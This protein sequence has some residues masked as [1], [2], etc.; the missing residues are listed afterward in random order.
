MKRVVKLISFI[1]LFIFS[2]ELIRR[3]SLFL[4]PNIKDFLLQSLTPVKAISIG[5]FTTS[6]VQSSG[7]I[8]T[9]TA[10]F[11]GNNLINL[12]TV[13]YILI[14]ASL[15]TTITALII[16][17]I[18]VTKQKKDFR[19]G[20]EIALS[21]S[22]YSA[23][24]VVIVFFLEYY[25]KLFSKLSFFLASILGE[26]ISLLKVPNFV[27]LITSPIIDFLFKRNNKLILLLFAFIILI[28]TLKY[29]GRSIIEV[30]GGE[31]K[32]KKFI[33]KYFDSKYKAYL[34]GVVLTAMVFS[35]S[36]TIG[37]LVPLAVSRL[38]SLKKAIPFILGADLGTF[39]DVFL[40]SIIIGKTTAFATS[41]AYAL[42]AII[43]ALIFLPNVDFLHKTTKYVSKKLIK[44]S[45]KK[46]LYILIAFILIPL[47]IILIF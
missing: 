42:F 36:I 16:S 34:I 25:L 40:A 37:L 8:A 31:D 24:L 32:A 12:P 7:A 30:F 39:S 13:I 20:F 6:I 47:G 1:Y 3:T 14:G 4:A 9:I 19:H 21:Y 27:D 29:I 35:S 43:G 45:R 18:T 23:F 26:K 28:F 5:W 10:A 15:G 46:A 2:I 11:A 44:I 22:I 17:L 38:I 41:I 33:N